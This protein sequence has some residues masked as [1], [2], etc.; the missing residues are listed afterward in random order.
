MKMQRP[1]AMWVS[2]MLAMAQATVAADAV[3]A[4]A[5]DP[6]PKAAVTSYLTAMKEKRFEAAYNFVTAT[7][8]DGSSVKD[9]AGLQRKMFELGGVTI[10]EIEVREAVVDLA[11]PDTCAPSAK[12]P[13][14]LHAGDVMNNQGSAEFEVYTVLLAKGKWQ[15]DSQETLVGND[16]IQHWFPGEKIPD[17]K[18]TADKP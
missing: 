10:G 6:G 9:W 3:P 5:K 14:V 2:V 12:V 1:L 13:N 11:K 18:G 8:T 15:I 16:A 7:M 17:Y 4:C